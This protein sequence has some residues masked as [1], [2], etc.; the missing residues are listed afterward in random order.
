MLGALL[1]LYVGDRL[2]RIK[3]LYVYIYLCIP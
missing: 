3:T 2:G 1:N